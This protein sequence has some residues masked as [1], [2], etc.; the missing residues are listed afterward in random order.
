MSEYKQPIPVPTPDISY[1]TD[2]NT[3]SARDTQISS[4]ARRVS[5]GDP[6][7]N[8]IKT[9]GMV[10]RGCKNTTRGKTSRGPMA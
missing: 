6:A 5:M 4:P 10:Q 1:P 3:V 8:D 2:P 7:R 9:T